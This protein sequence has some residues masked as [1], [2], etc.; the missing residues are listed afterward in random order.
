MTV[1]IPL[2]FKLQGMNAC[3]W[4]DKE[5]L[6]KSY[7]LSWTIIV[8]PAMVLMTGL[9]SR[10]VYALW[11]KREPKN[12]LTYQQRVCINKQVQ[13]VNIFHLLS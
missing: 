9:Y 5:W 4:M 8:V 6:Q 12:Q 3:V 10:I 2:L 11:F 7:V 1:Q 13:R